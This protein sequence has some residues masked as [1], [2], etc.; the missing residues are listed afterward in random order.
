MRTCQNTYYT[1]PVLFRSGSAGKIIMLQ[2]VHQIFHSPLNTEHYKLTLI[3][4]QLFT[5]CLTF[6]KPTGCV[7]HQ[8]F[9]IQQLYALSTLY[10]CVLFLSENKQR[11]V[12]LTA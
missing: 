4:A 12:P 2:L 7:M 6:L 8:Q 3:T 10:L 5:C 9:T 1:L 11:L